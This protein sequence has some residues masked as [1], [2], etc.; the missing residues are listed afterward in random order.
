VS[1]EVSAGSFFSLISL[2]LQAYLILI[3][4]F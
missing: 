4:L 2:Y 1:E 3:C